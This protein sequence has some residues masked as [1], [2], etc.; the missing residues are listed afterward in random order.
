MKNGPSTFTTKWH[1]RPDAEK[2]RIQ[3]MEAKLSAKLQLLELT[4]GKTKN[5]AVS[6]NLEKIRRHKEALQ[7]I[8]AGVEELKRDIQQE[9]LDKGETVD[10]VKE[11]EEETEGK[12]DIVDQD[13]K[14][15]EARLK[16]IVTR[17][18]NEERETKEYHLARE[19][20][21]QLKF[22]R[23]QLEQKAEFSKA[24]NSTTDLPHKHSVK[25]P[26]LVITKYNG[27][28]ENWLSFWNKFE[29]EIDSTDLP[30]VTKFAYLKELVEPRVRK[31]I[32]GLPFTTEGY[33]RAKSILKSNYGKMSE[34]VNAYI[35]NILA[36][37][38]ISG[39]QPAKVHDFYEALLYN[40]Q[41]L[42]TLG[43]TSECV[44][45]VRGIL[46]KLPGIKAELVQG[47]PEWQS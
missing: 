36:L 34:I 8:V 9:K 29:A 42:E 19:R 39:T 12:M 33:E 3:K 26:K 27:A 24:Q 18:E 37:P 13:I 30:A 7:T 31:G 41:S 44:A 16:E 43:K 1:L 23:H 17:S 32:D 14:F 45:L 4:R 25:L 11:R 35:E 28:L 20:E 5:V 21:E 40:V 10:E 6:D 22:E 46:N 38:F 2:H 47:H 15:V